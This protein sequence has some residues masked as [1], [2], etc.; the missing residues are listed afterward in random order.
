MRPESWQPP[1]CPNPNCRHHTAVGGVWPFKRSGAYR[2]QT[3]PFRIRRFQCRECRRCFS[4][5][6]FSVTYW[7]KKPGILPDVF[8]QTTSCAAHRQIAHN[9]GVAPDTVDRAVGRLGRHCLLAHLAVWGQKPPCG[10][11]AIDGL[12]TFEWSQFFPFHANVAVEVESGFFSFFTDSELRRRGRMTDW[13]RRRRQELEDQLGR[14]DPRAVVRGISELLGVVLAGVDA[15]VIRSDDHPA[16][17]GPI[18]RSACHIRHEVTSSKRR[19]DGDNA[20]FEVNLLDLWI[21]HGSANHKRET[22]AWSKRRQRAMER[23]AIVLVDR[24]YLRSR[25]KKRGGPTP[26]M[27][28]GVIDRKLSVEEVL[29]ARRFPDQFN[30]PCPWDRYYRGEVETQAL[31]VN[32]RHALKYA[33]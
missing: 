15:V 21:R 23:L 10:A 6:T 16:Y 13:Q 24:N 22:I 9:L 28:R 26:G 27:L 3:A 14:P 19:R 33:F 8:R 7:M 17:R 25:W 31:P 4:T 20:L 30:L 12:E 2:R 5:Q 11:V 29:A 32:R 18:R 1:F